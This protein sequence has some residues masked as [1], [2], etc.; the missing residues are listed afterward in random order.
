MKVIIDTSVWSLA[1]RR[2]KE[3][4]NDLESQIIVELVELIKETRAIIIGPIRQELLSGLNP[5]SQFE[6]LKKNLRAFDDLS[7][8]RED[9]ETASNFFNTCR[10]NGIQGSQIDFLICAVSHNNKISIL[11]TDKDFRQY[12]NFIDIKLHKIRD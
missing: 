9:Y 5:N 11:T 10:R 7:I 12:S 1:L 3:E 6:K 4:L 8:K 2:K